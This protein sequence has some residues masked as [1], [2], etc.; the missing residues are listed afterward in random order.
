MQIFSDIKK[1]FFL[2]FAVFFL[3]LPGFAAEK[4]ISSQPPLSM[5]S[6]LS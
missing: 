1:L 3:D 2:I 5:F 4:D 6:T